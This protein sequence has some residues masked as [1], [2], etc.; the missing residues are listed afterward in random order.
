MANTVSGQLSLKAD[1]GISAL[2]HSEAHYFNRFVDA[3]EF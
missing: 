3:R 2:P 1:E